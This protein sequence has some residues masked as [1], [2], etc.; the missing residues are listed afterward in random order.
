MKEKSSLK[1]ILKRRY[2]FTEKEIFAR[3]LCGE[4]YVNNEKINTPGRL[5]RNDS[6]IELKKKRNFVSRGGDKLN[7]IL[8]SW[9]INVI[10]KI[11]IDA[12][13]STGGFTDCLIQKGA[14]LVYAV[15]V[16]YNQLDYSLRN[17]KKVFIYERKNIMHMN[18]S[19][20]TVKPDSAV[21][22]L[23]FRSINNAAKH[24]LGLVKEEYIIAL[25]KPQFEWRMPDENFNGVIEDKKILHKI[26]INLVHALWKEK[27]Y[28]SKVGI[29]PIKGRKGNNEFFFLINEKENIKE[30]VILKDI[31]TLIAK[32][33]PG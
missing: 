13:C 21:V 9:N 15:D 2:N 24:I 1:E 8:D 18:E 6:I 29:S 16:G 7:P 25:I 33:I 5:I 27:T 32:R 10:D 28:I 30:T 4:V 22:D 3:I 31:E 17:N 12:G 23:S 14:K 11:F 20:F 19:D 26:L